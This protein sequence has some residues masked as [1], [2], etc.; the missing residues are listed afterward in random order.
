MEIADFGNAVCSDI[1]KEG[2]GVVERSQHTRISGKFERT[3]PNRVDL[4][5]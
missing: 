1:D 3:K 4:A 2:F 5:K